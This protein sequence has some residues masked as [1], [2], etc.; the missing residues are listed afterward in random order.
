[1][2]AWFFLFVLY[3]QLGLV[4]L[5]ANL[6]MGAFSLGLSEKIVLRWGIRTPLVIGMLLVSASLV[7]KNAVIAMMLGVARRLVG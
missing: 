6:I 5:P 4:F 1:M 2:F 7:I 3:L